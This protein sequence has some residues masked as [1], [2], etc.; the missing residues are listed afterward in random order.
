MTKTGGF[1][2]LILGEH[3][4]FTKEFNEDA[5]TSQHVEF[6][7]ATWTRHAQKD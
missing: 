6:N 7:V 4:G 1:L 5:K 3:E 2:K